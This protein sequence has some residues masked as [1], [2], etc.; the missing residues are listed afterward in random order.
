MFNSWQLQV[1]RPVTAI[2]VINWLPEVLWVL[3]IPAFKWLDSITEEQLLFNWK[4]VKIS[5]YGGYVLEFLGSCLASHKLVGLN[6]V[7]KC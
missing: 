1:M 2:L 5:Q 4:P 6:M 3:T 7:I